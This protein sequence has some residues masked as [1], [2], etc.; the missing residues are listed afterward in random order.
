MKN[1][2]AVIVLLFI[3]SSLVISQEIIQVDE[4]GRLELVS[5]EGRRNLTIFE[6]E[7]FN[8]RP[9]MIPVWEHTT[10]LVDFFHFVKISTT[11]KSVYYDGQYMKYVD[12]EKQVVQSEPKFLVYK[13][14]VIFALVLLLFSNIA[15]MR[16]RG[17]ISLLFALS[18]TVVMVTLF[19]FGN[20][21]VLEVSNSSTTLFVVV[22]VAT[23]L[24]IF[25]SAHA[26]LPKEDQFFSKRY[27]FRSSGIFYVLC[28]ISL[29]LK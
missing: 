20:S 26:H 19:L 16:G 6:E 18:A 21:L 2:I 25:V 4:T 12:T 27:Y 8:N 3:T 7:A 17:F 13:L 1:I 22:F 5:K 15:N 29:F 10:Q 9:N 24:T 11:T 14:I 23:S 28:F